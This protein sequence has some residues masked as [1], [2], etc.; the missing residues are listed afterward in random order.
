MNSCSMSNLPVR[1]CQ[2]LN[3][4]WQFRQK[5]KESWHSATVPGCN[6]TD[7]LQLGL[8]KDPFYR[9]E[10]NRLQWIEQHDWEYKLEFEVSE[11]T[12]ARDHILLVFEGLD[13]YCEVYLNGT[14]L[15]SSQNMFVGHRIDCKN[16]LVAGHNQ[17]Y[18]VFRSPVNEVYPLY[19]KNGFTYPAEN[20]KSIER[21][22]VYT[23]KAPYHYGWDWGP[24]FVTSGIWRSVSIEAFNKNS[25][26]SVNYSL[27]SIN[28]LSADITFDVQLSHQ[29]QSAGEI[30]ISC[31]NEHEIELS[32]R[33]AGSGSSL[34]I[35]LSVKNPR[36][37]WPNGLGEAFLYHFKIELWVEGELVDL[38]AVEVGLREIEVIN[39]PD[40]DGESFYFKVNGHPVFMKGANY[41]PSD[42]FLNRV[43][44]NRYRQIFE[45]A[46]GANM[47]MLRVWGGGVYEDDEFY[48]LAN[49][50]GI[51]IW[52]DF[53]FACTLYPAAPDFI[54][55]VKQEA[56]YN[57]KRLRNHPCI[58]IWCGNNEI[59]MGM[60][61][62]QWQ[63]KFDYSETLY[64]RL[65][66][67]YRVLF[68][69]VL[70]ASVETHDPS[71][72]YFSSSPIGF[73]EVVEDDKRGDNH[74]W[75]VW[76]GEQP[77]SEFRNR[78]P[79]FM[80]EY[81]F[82]SFPS[83]QSVE[84]YS[85]PEDWVIESEVMRV[86]QKHP[87]GN[88]L[89][90]NYML[91]EYRKPKDFVSFLYMSQVLQAQG[92]KVGFEA[93]RLA[94]PFCMGTLYWQFNDCWPV[95]SWSS[96]DYY[97]RW[98]AMHYQAK[99][100][101]E[102]I[103]VMIEESDQQ[104]RV[105]V[106][107]DNLESDILQLR[108]E[109]LTFDGNPIWAD[110]SQIKIAANACTLLSSHPIEFYLEGNQLNNIVLVATLYKD[111]T[112]IISEA[113]HYF[114]LT[115]DLSLNKPD[116]KL[117]THI[118]NKSL[119]VDIQTNTL[120]RQMYLS[121]EGIVANFSDNFFDLLPNTIKTVTLALP[122]N[123]DI[124]EDKLPNALSVMSVADTY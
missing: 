76:H 114:A 7:L 82:Q 41:I 66:E 13:T 117:A 58:A 75:G 91:Q 86:H 77:F 72:F 28:E 89:I 48:K 119:T 45:D 120:V 6:F 95:A 121:V 83:M 50:Y 73:W 57:I 67:D 56:E 70:P 23:R 111:Q 44:K 54:E 31:V 38:K 79:R 105:S 39:Q 107:N 62:W 8:I 16:Q 108:L 53:M 14:L 37:W 90:N 97:G 19:T 30:K 124:T 63:E 87:R 74:F 109:L 102:P 42:S 5:G 85:E 93:H 112:E 84:N 104:I 1:T 110:T 17:L 22:S 27:Q 69:E 2:S 20:D 33:L 60:E 40:Q 46:V 99:R 55:N 51:L 43:D 118:S 78:V 21:L 4:I 64:N 65:R 12:L 3:G 59:E 9:A 106:V 80:S 10:E 24:R 68:K 88:Q 49:E 25:I 52:Q 29:N 122:E 123:C 11:G 32:E 115:K 34:Q 92:M 100:S 35:D 113:H 71:R 47:N 103:A 15:L 26:Q 96:I 116:L 94:M 98:K 18:L 61:T 101:F 81:G 36:R